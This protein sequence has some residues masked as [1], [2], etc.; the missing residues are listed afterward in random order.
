MNNNS[1]RLLWD[2]LDRFNKFSDQLSE[3]ITSDGIDLKAVEA[4]GKA[5]SYTLLGYK[6]IDMAIDPDFDITDYRRK[7]VIGEALEP[8][9]P[10]EDCKTC[11]FPC[12]ERNHEKEVFITDDS[13]VPF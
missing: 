13:D 1:N 6:Q 10:H 11:P 2:L 5:Y 4:I 8:E 3:A 9:C 7:E 12:D